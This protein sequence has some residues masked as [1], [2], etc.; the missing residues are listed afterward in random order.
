MIIK[1]VKFSF[2]DRE[3]KLGPYVEFF[4]ELEVPSLDYDSIV[5]VIQEAHPEYEQVRLLS[6][7]EK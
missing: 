7:T 1:D 5:N 2:V 3:Y 6:L 4:A